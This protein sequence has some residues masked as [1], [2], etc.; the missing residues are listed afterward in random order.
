MLNKQNEINED[1]FN[2]IE[3]LKGQIKDRP[4]IQCKLFQIDDLTV[5]GI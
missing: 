1:M 3:S 5:T 4:E 2:Q